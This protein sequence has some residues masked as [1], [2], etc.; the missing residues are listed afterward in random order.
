MTYQKAGYIAIIKRVLGWVIFIPALLSTIV[1]VIN[2]AW[3]HGIKGSGINA[4]LDDFL[5]MM[6]EMVRFN[7]SFLDFFWK[8]SPTPVRLAG[9]TGENMSFLIIYFLIFVGL[10]MNAS[11][12][13]MYRQVKF[14]RENIEDQLIIEKVKDNGG[15]TREQIE[16]RIKLPHHTLFSQIYI[17]YVSPVIIGAIFYFLLGI[18]GW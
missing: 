9:F 17:L 1:S 2:L 11:G 5:K 3:L 13:R 7:T 18:L 12:Q 8:N 16:S 6:A 15:L 14:V 4:V 10:A